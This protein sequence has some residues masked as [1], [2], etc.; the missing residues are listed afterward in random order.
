MRAVHI[1]RDFSLLFIV[2]SIAALVAR[3]LHV[4]TLLAYIS[5]APCLDFPSEPAG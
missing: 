1:I 5:A 3:I 4:P 2:A